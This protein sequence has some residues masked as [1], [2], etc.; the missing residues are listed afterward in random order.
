MPGREM[1]KITST[2]NPAQNTF[3]RHRPRASASRKAFHSPRQLQ[4]LG[5]PEDELHEDDPHVLRF[6]IIRLFT[7]V[8]ASDLTRYNIYPGEQELR[9][10]LALQGL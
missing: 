7:M 2:H 4:K 10:K 1:G 9:I 5:W 3:R 8:Q 6:K